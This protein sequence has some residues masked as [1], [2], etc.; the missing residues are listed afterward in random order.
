MLHFLNLTLK[1]P[2]LHKSSYCDIIP[3]HN[4]LT[5]VAKK[6]WASI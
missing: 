1:S 4:P 6:S 5:K 3:L 2:H